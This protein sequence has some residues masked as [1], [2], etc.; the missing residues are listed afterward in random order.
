GVE[1]GEPGVQG[2]RAVFGEFGLQAGAH[3]RVGAGE[4]EFVQGGAH[5]QAG[6]AD[7]DGDAARGAEVVDDRAGHALVVG[8]VRGLGDVPDVEQVVGDAAPLVGGELGGTDV[9]APVQLHGVG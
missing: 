7:Q 4:V 3:L 1:A 9:H 2:E 8:R 5:V 6:A